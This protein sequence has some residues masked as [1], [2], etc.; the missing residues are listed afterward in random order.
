M[1]LG[2]LV[3]LRMKDVSKTESGIYRMTVYAGHKEKYVT[4]CSLECAQAID[5]Y[6]AYRKR[7]GERIGPDSPFIR[8]QFDRTKQKDAEN[9]KPISKHG[10]QVIVY[11][12]LVDS[13]LRERSVESNA[14]KRK[15]IMMVHGFRKFF[16]TE[17]N[18]AYKNQNP[19]MVELLLGHDPEL[20]GDYNKVSNAAKEEFYLGGMNALTIDDSFRLQKQVKELEVKAKAGEKVEA[21]EKIVAEST[22]K[23]DAVS[24][25]MAE[26]AEKNRR[27]EERQA[28]YDD[29]LSDPAK[30]KKFLE[31]S[32]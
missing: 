8:N 16:S 27:M 21:L 29:L 12:L 17:L 28:L 31:Q 22:I 19:M 15:E 26:L 24:K 9:S 11:F 10:L 14:F 4:F 23:H 6:L 3:D 25:Q 5:S 7:C 20:P 2:G 30:L 13:G 18:A 32:D 1:R